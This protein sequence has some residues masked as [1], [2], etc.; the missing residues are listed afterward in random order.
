VWRVIENFN[1]SCMVHI[2]YNC[3]YSCRNVYSCLCNCVQLAITVRRRP[4]NSCYACEVNSMGKIRVRM[5]FKETET[6]IEGE[7]E[8]IIKYLE[9]SMKV[10]GK[11]SA[12]LAV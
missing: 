2:G 5:Y 10:F 11:P 1:G 8:D 12:G 6:E 4:V 3:D 7:P 9:L